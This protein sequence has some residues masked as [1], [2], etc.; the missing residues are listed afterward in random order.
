[1]KAI[2]ISYTGGLFGE[3]FSYKLQQQFKNLEEITTP[4]NRYLFPNYLSAIDFRP[5]V[6]PANTSWPISIEQKIKLHTI[7]KDKYICIP[8]HWYSNNLMDCNIDP[9]IGIRLYSDNI[10]I[11]N[12]AYAL[13]WVKSYIY[14]NEAWKD[15][16]I[17]IK[18]LISS[19]HKYSKELSNLLIPG[20]Y[21]S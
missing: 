2:I 15:R 9:F 13:F 4:E 10:K 14:A 3:F 8:T 6:F 20:N 17:E 7:Y 5:K 12:F 18:N 21:Q 16:V 1:M 11:L 19:G